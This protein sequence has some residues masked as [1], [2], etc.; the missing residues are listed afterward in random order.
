MK[1]VEE[2]VVGN[3]M[4]TVWDCYFLFLDFHIRDNCLSWVK[5]VGE[6]IQGQICGVILES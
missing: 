3:F 6:K 5:R 4:S 1:T 2:K